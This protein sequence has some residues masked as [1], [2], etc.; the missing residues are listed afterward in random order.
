MILNPMVSIVC[1]SYNHGDYLADAI[2]SFLMQKTDFE[3]EILLYDDASTDHGPQVIKQ[4][5]S[6]YPS[7]IK[8]IYETQNQ[9]SQGVRVEL[10]N[11]N[12]A[13]GKY[14]AVCEGDDYWTDPYK[15]QKQV[16]YMEAHPACSM[17]V[18]AADRVYSDKK[19][20]L[21]TVRPEKEDIILP[22]ERVIEGGGDLVATNS[23]VY[24]KEKVAVLP[25]FYL[26]AVVGDYPL[27]I[28]A[29][30]HGTVN[31]LD[32]NMSAYRVGVP[33][34]WTNRELATSE[35]RVKHY[36]DMERMFDEIN[37][38]TH[39]KYTDSLTKAKLGYEFS[40]LLEEGRF[41]E[42]K[43]G[44]YRTIYLELSIKK[45]MIMEFKRC[46]PRI[47]ESIRKIKWKMI[48]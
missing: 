28:L 3:I 2:D 10:F 44:E 16:D 17:T 14:I 5:A 33:G 29:A 38:Y 21:S 48:H 30:L 22:I 43:H 32:E 26:N 25:P 20:V 39:Y 34:S 9:Y 24:S 47:T 40:L 4:Y 18:H 1:T 27:A 7:L 12:R 13:K 8:P 41:N 23:M 31:Y 37:A 36:Q 45:R 11:H 19:K 6:D 15:L 35:K 46:F 42:A